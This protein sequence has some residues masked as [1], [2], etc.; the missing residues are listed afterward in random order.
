MAASWAWSK[1]LMVRC[2][3]A[4]SA[5]SASAWACSK[6]VCQGGA[7]CWGSSKVAKAVAGAAA[8]GATGKSPGAASCASACSTASWLRPRAQSSARAALVCS[9]TPADCASGSSC[10]RARSPLSTVAPSTTHTE[11]C[12]R[13][14]PAR[15]RCS[16][17]PKAPSRSQ[18]MPG[19][20]S[21]GSP[22]T[23]SVS[24]MPLR[25]QPSSSSNKGRPQGP[26]RAHSTCWRALPSCCATR[27]WASAKCSESETSVI[28]GGG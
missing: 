20:W 18:A 4:R 14:A 24:A 13:G 3:S 12:K 21:W 19:A 22:D 1:A 16:V 23:T 26:A 17:A 2:M 9:S 25:Q 28:A 6:A 15:S 27:A 8:A 11:V 10:R 7:H 5:C